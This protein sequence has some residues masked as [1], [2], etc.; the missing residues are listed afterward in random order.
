MLEIYRSLMVDLNYEVPS[1]SHTLNDL[2]IY[3]KKSTQK[4]QYQKYSCKKKSII[5][6]EKSKILKIF[7][8]GAVTRV[9]KYKVTITA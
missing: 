4:N 1:A 3:R 6:V 7:F 9:L 8:L 5:P 2:Y